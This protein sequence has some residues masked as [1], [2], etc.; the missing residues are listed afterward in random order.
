MASLYVV[1]HG[2]SIFRRGEQLVVQKEDRVLAEVELTSLS[3]IVMLES[4]QVTS[5]A[6]RA[7]LRAG[8]SLAFVSSEGDLLGKLV[9]PMSRNA[10]LRLAQFQKET[11]PISPWCRVRRS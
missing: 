8:V 6:L 4:V 10:T 11:A 3:S 1:E 5:Q 7:I 2:A 9:P